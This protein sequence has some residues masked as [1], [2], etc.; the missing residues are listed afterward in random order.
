MSR[1][2]L[3][4]AALALGTSIEA[5]AQRQLRYSEKVGDYTVYYS[6]VPSASIADSIKQRLH[7]AVS[8]NSEILNVAVDEHDRNVEADIHANVVNRAGQRRD[9]ELRKVEEHDRVSYLGVVRVE[10]ADVL[11][12]SL[13][14]FPEDANR[15][16]KIEFSERI[17][18]LPRAGV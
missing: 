5:T 8:A 16:F 18:R 17:N 12:F 13:E 15:P 7:L 9:I 1:W 10:A 2:V 6:V 11:K 3:I 14:V 4:W